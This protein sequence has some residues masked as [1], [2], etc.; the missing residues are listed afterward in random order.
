MIY[1]FSWASLFKDF[2][3]RQYIQKKSF[4]YSDLLAEIIIKQSNLFIFYDFLAYLSLFFFKWVFFWNYYSTLDHISIIFYRKSNTESSKCRVSADIP[5][6]FRRSNGARWRH[7]DARPYTYTAH[8][9]ARVSAR[10]VSSY[11]R[12]SRRRARVILVYESEKSYEDHKFYP[13]RLSW[14]RSRIPNVLEIVYAIESKLL[15]MFLCHLLCCY[16]H[17]YDKCHV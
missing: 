15:L 5:T 16:C 3:T 7:R 1:T 11:G 12:R 14:N 13:W 17:E 6:R 8:N 2:S 4:K 10:G 9:L